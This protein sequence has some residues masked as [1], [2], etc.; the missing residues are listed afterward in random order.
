[1]QWS[2][3]IG[4]ATVA[5]FTTAGLIGFASG[6]EATTTGQEFTAESVVEKATVYTVDP[7]HSFV[8]FRIKH[9]DVS[10]AYG[11]F[12]EMSGEFNIDD[13]DPAASSL[14]IEIKTESVDTANTNRDEHLRSPDFFD[15][16]Q[17]PTAKFKSTEIRS[18]GENRYEVKGDLSFHGETKPVTVTL[19]HVGESDTR[20]GRRSGVESTFTIDRGA[21][22]MGFMEGMLG[23]EVTVTV[24]L[25][26]IEKK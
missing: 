1:M 9:L 26:G 11:R 3:T 23:D 5:I 16:R 6:E 20:R 25:E 2:K 17:Y 4:A 8:V 14:E 12:N 7:V 18:V 24:A 13:A 19:V 22:G 10:Y 21:Y 15:V